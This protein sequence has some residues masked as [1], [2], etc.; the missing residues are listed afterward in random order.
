MVSFVALALGWSRPRLAGFPERALFML[1]RA[2]EVVLG[3]LGL[4]A[5]FSS[6]YAGGIGAGTPPNLA[7]TAVYVASGSGCPWF[8]C[9]FGDVFDLVKPMARARPRQRAGWRHG[10]S[11]EAGRSRSRIPEQLRQA[12]PPPP[13]RSRLRHL[14]A[15]LGA[16]NQARPLAL[17]MLGG[18]CSFGMSLY[19]V[20]PWG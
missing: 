6:V 16:R 15:V 8:R 13:A 4:F 9:W 19:G 3:A 18:D 1:P 10:L 5:F 14:R 11:P 12:C 7:P 2:A 20:D 17:V